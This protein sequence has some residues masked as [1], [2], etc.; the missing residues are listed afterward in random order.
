MK[1]LPLL[2]LLPLVI[3]SEILDNNQFLIYNK[4][5]HKARIT[6]WG[7]NGDNVGTYEKAVYADQLWTL[8]PHP[9]K[10]GCYY[11]VNE[12]HPDYRIADWKH[13]FV[14]FSGPHY[15]DQLFKFEPSGNGD[16]YYYII[17]CRY[18]NDRMAKYGHGDRDVSMYSG[19]RYQDQ[20][21]RLVPRFTV[22]IRTD[23]VFHF[24]NRQGSSPVPKEITV[25]TGMK[26]SSTSTIR[27]KQT[28]KTTMEASV[29]GAFKGIN[30]GAKASTEITKEIETTFSETSESNW[31]K[32]DKM[33]FTVLP[34]KNYKVM[35][36]VVKFESQL[37]GDSYTLL[38]AVK[39]FESDTAYFEDNDHFIIDS[40]SK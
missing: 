8:E 13:K 1:L 14:V 7:A 37:P 28:L 23:E 4:R 33:K 34:G 2:L 9:T 40:H 18:P 31:S 21:W 11:M 38:S 36:R 5:Y 35:Q 32:T 27:N 16:G 17:S 29:G 10:T 24:D 15:N 12:A 19:P 26:K 25:T 39:V 3:E 22:S 20:L 30:F 6:Q